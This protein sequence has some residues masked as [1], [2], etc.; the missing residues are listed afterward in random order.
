MEQE[1]KIQDGECLC[2]FT[3]RDLTCLLMACAHTY[4]EMSE[5]RLDDNPGFSLL[6]KD[7]QRQ[8]IEQIGELRPR[9]TQM[10]FDAIGK[11]NAEQAMAMVEQ[12]IMEDHG[13][14][15]N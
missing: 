8:M 14:K 15:P 2:I 9:V 11:D 12:R 7:H 4:R 10:I 3:I 5:G 13:T 6:S 1:M